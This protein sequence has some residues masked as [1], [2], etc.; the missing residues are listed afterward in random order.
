MAISVPGIPCC[1]C[2]PRCGWRGRWRGPLAGLLF[3]AGTLFPALGFFNVY[4]FRFSF[5]ADHFQYLADLGML[6]LASAGAALLL[7]RRRL[8]GWAGGNLLCLALLLVLAG[9]TWRQSRMYADVERFWR[10]TIAR[11]P[12]A[13]MARNNYGL[14]LLRKDKQTRRLRSS[15]NHW[16][17]TPTIHWPTTTLAL[18]CFKGDK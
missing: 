7:G 6:T 17:S 4:P 9:L 15:K 2:C 11:N 3:F 8:W 1:W 18:F 13:W 12:D 10:T 16:P 14:A 5:V